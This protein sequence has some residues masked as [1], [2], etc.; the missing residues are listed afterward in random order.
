MST[1]S[2]IPTVRRS[3][4]VGAP[5]ER[6]F[7]VFTE[8]FNAWWP[9][10]YHIGKADFAE[11]VLELREG[12]RWYERGT[13]GS[14]C[15]WGRVLAWEPPHRLV[16]TWQINGEWQYDPDPQ[17]ASEVE[18]RFTPDGSERTTVELEHRRIERLVAAQAAYGAVG[19]DGGWGTILQ[20]FADAVAK[21]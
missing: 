13:D 4:S 20:R 16:V 1:V 18:V 7:R 14:E 17:H 6:A 3:I 8:S 12:G 9:A 19:G 11:A 15:D 21:E 5:V 10:D 2:T